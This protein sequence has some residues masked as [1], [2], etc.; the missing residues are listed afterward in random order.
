MSTRIKF[1]LVCLWALM[2]GLCDR[3]VQ[4][5]LGRGA[6]PLG[7]RVNNVEDAQKLVDL[8]VSYEHDK[9]DTSRMY[10]GGTSEE[11]ISQLDLKG[12]TVDTKVFP[13]EAGGLKAERVKEALAASAKALGSVK[14]QTFYLHKPDRST[15]IEETLRAIN[16][17]YKE[18]AFE[19]FGL[20]N[21]MSWEVAEVITTADKHGWIKP[22][23]YQ[24]LY[25]VIERNVEVE[26]FPCLRHFGI[27]FYAYSPLASGALSERMLNEADTAKTGGR[28]D[29]NVSAL[30]ARLQKTYT[31]MRPAIRELNDSL[32][33]NNISLSE[34]AF[35][36]LQHHSKLDP[37]AGDRII[38]GASSPI[39]L[40]SNL[41]ER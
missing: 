14:I 9:L 5:K 24:G 12:C 3:W 38:I 39:Q 28:W 26:L 21:F 6:P 30:A 41:K 37:E 17:L 23:I 27:R 31:P 15:P 4:P 34:A 22:T 19:E 8:F 20:S 35:R 25:N 33:K 36:W 1:I 18:G 10:G 32:A 40:E 13:T 2:H 29:P 11:L 16:D 7:A